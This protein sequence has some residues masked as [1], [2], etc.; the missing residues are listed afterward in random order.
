[1][2]WDLGCDNIDRSIQQRILSACHHSQATTQTSSP[3]L[4]INIVGGIKPAIKFTVILRKIREK[5][6]NFLGGCRHFL[7]THTPNIALATWIYLIKTEV[8]IE[9]FCAVGSTVLCSLCERCE[10]SN[11]WKCSQRC[12]GVN[13][14]GIRTNVSLIQDILLSIS[15]CASLGG[16]FFFLFFS[17]LLLLAVGLYVCAKC[18]GPQKLQP[19]MLILFYFVLVDELESGV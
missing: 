16:F 8:A 14:D 17:P 12:T 2:C 7:H 4:T 6:D 11:E 15:Y 1:M 9:A 10:A 5:I 19:F 3:E 18:Y 13:G